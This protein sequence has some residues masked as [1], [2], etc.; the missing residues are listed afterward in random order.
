MTPH[1]PLP[2]Q[3]PGGWQWRCTCG[4]RG[5]LVADWETANQGYI[6]HREM[7]KERIQ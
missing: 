6:V 3:R 4:V 5:P 2:P 1:M 7:K